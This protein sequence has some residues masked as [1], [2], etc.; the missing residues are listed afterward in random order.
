MCRY[1]LI[2]FDLDG[3]LLD[4]SKGIFN[5][6]RYAEKQMKLKMIPDE[7]LKEFVGPP[8]KQMYMNI[9]GLDESL[10]LLAARYHREYGRTKAVYE[11][12]PYPDMA[13]TLQQLKS[14]GYKLG[15][16]TL[17][18]QEIAEEVL[19]LNGMLDSF[20][21]VVG[22]DKDE[23]LKKVD[24]IHKAQ[25]YT[26][27]KKTVLVGDSPYDYEGAVAAGI[28]F[29]G[30]LYGFGFNGSKIYPFTTIKR[31]NE[32]LRLLIK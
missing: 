23:T 1:D 25:L 11:A 27:A 10:A 14:D 6:V 31:P 4:T 16:A 29:I 17:K 21:C 20:A 22:M 5:S 30:V 12:E 19:R 13:G 32:L 24:T 7:R 26:N 28:D 8:P 15:V 9:Y 3:T 2:L 18:S